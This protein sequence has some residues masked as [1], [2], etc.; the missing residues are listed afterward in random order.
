[1][2]IVYISVGVWDHRPS[3][4]LTAPHKREVP[5]TSNVLPAVQVLVLM[6]PSKLEDRFWLCSIGILKVNCFLILL[7]VPNA[8]YRVWQLYHVF[9]FVQLKPVLKYV[10]FWASI[11]LLVPVNPYGNGNKLLGCLSIILGVWTRVHIFYLQVESGLTTVKGG[12]TTMKKELQSHTARI[13]ELL[14][15][16]SLGVCIVIR[17]GN[18]TLFNSPTH[19]TRIEL[20]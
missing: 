13:M 6:V 1:M 20:C 8:M 4:T 9:T 19:Y 12:V 7:R 10:T 11:P 15:L 16:N 14:G 2:V 17:S 5:T 18:Y 3:I